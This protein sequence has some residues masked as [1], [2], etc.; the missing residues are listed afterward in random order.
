MNTVV[1]HRQFR[2]VIEQ[3]LTGL[4]TLAEKRSQSAL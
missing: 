3:M 1:M 2:T 4:C